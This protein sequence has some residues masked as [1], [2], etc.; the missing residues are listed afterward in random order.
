MCIRY[1]CPEFPFMQH[2]MYII[3]LLEMVRNLY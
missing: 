1:S 3:Q 2:L